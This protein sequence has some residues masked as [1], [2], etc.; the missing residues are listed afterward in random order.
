MNLI[1][2]SIE[3]F[4]GWWGAVVV[5]FPLTVLTISV[6]VA[7]GL[8]VGT[9]KLQVTTDPIE[10]WA[11]P[12]SRSRVEKDFFDKQFRPF[13]R[14][15]LVVVKAI[16][17]DELGMSKIHHTDYLGNVKEFTAMF[18]KK[19]LKKVLELQKDIE[20][21]TFDFEEQYGNDITNVCNKPLAPFN[22]NCNINSI[23][24]Y[25]HDEVNYIISRKIQ[26]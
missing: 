4:F 26:Y 2:D 17:N 3:V 5:K 12:T 23:W 9:I 20:K 21:I 15:A 22:S 8:S 18:Q 14:T 24:A 13:Y 16:E 11:A 6:L 10:L 1:N 25:W 19:F 7:A